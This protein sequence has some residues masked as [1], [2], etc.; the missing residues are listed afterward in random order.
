LHRQSA[1][2]GDAGRKALLG[3]LRLAP[4]AIRAAARGLGE[5]NGLGGGRI[6]ARERI[7]LLEPEITIIDVLPLG[8]PRAAAGEMHHVGRTLRRLLAPALE[9]VPGDGK[10]ADVL[11]LHPLHA[12]QV[13]ATLAIDDVGRERFDGGVFA[14]EEHQ[15]RPILAR[16]SVLHLAVHLYRFFGLVVVLHAV[17]RLRRLGV[18]FE[19]RDVAEKEKIAIAEQ[20]PALIAG[21][22]GRQKP[23]VGELGR[24]KRIFFAMEESASAQIVELDRR[25]LHRDR[26]APLERKF[27]DVIGDGLAL[28]P[29]N[30]NAKR[31]CHCSNSIVI[32]ANVQTQWSI[33]HAGTKVHQATPLLALLSFLRLLEQ[34]P[35]V[36]F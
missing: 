11:V 27:R 31:I 20:R 18:F 17:N 29:A 22:R 33:H 15:R 3:N 25:H 1:Q 16:I 14:V 32:V 10:I 5:K 7:A 35:I 30:E 26:R 12:V 21:E 24:G 23:G 28:V 4:L 13:S 2:G 9:P 19:A 34:K 8:E 6:R 36:C